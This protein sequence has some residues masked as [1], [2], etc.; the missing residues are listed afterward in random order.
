[1]NRDLLVVNRISQS[2][3]DNRKGFTGYAGDIIGSNVIRFE[4]G[5]NDK[6]FIRSIS[7]SDAQTI[8]QECTFQFKNQICK[9]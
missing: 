7:F 4:N 6:V 8:Q 5:P 2:A 9:P 1:M 3:A